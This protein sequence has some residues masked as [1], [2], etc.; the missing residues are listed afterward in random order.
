MQIKRKSYNLT[1]DER[2]ANR[3]DEIVSD[4]RVHVAGT[5]IVGARAS[6]DV[7]TQRR[8]R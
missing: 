5:T 1:G 7:P 3:G 2:E 6:R 8:L 4:T